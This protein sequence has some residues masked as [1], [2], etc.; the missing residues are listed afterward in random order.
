[1]TTIVETPKFRR[2]S[3]QDVPSRVLLHNISWELYEQLREEESNWGVRMAYD[4]GELEIMSPSQSHGEIE[5]RFGIFL[6][7]LA[8]V[9]DFPCKPVGNTTWK[10]P[11]AKKAKEAD[12]SYYL[13]NYERV[14]HKKIDLNV[15]PPPD[16]A[17][18]A[19]VSRSVL[20]ALDIYASIGVPEIWRFDGEVF[21]IHQRQA[22]GTYLEVNRSDALPFLRPEEVVFWMTK[23]EEMDNDIAWK[24]ELR[25]WARVELVPRLEPGA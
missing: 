7:E 2:S 4:D 14:R 10:K 22:D 18:E 24:R 15:D 11:G 13:A 21:H 23:A 9:L 5:A 16:L 3:K 20:N 12:G 8:D 17:V 25:E 6:T 19:E 1:M